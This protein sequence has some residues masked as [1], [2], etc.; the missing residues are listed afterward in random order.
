MLHIKKKI[1]SLSLI[2]R[3]HATYCCIIKLHASTAEYC[4]WLLFAKYWLYVNYYLISMT[5]LLYRWCFG[6]LRN[7]YVDITY[8][9]RVKNSNY[10]LD[11]CFYTLIKGYL[12]ILPSKIPLIVLHIIHEN[13]MFVNVFINTDSKIPLLLT[14]QHLSALIASVCTYFSWHHT[15]STYSITD[16]TVGIS[17]H[18]CWHYRIFRYLYITPDTA[19]QISF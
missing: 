19:E 10:L 17:F 11:L 14:L 9:W 5:S 12:I 4:F 7:L 6:N 16:S 13:Y 1:S 15:I 18:S 3:C 8:V 2:A